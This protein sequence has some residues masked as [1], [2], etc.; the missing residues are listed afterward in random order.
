MS[1][2][3]HELDTP[4]QRRQITELERRGFPV[5]RMTRYHVK[6]GKVNYYITKGTIT[7]DP[8]IRHGEKG[9]E[10][11]LELLDSTRT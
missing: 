4:E 1:K 8:T 10:S 6:I 9:F 5:R 11:L 7:I 3:F 2:L